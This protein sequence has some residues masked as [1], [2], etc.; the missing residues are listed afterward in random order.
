MWSRLLISLCVCRVHNRCSGQLKSGSLIEVPHC[1]ERRFFFLG[2][3]VLKPRLQVLLEGEVRSG[4]PGRVHIF[5][6]GSDETVWLTS[7]QLFQRIL[8]DS[9]DLKDIC[10]KTY[11]Y[12]MPIDGPLFSVDVVLESAVSLTLCSSPPKKQQTQ[13]KKK[14]PFGLVFQPRK[15][16]RTVKVS[17]ESGAQ[18]QRKMKQQEQKRAPKPLA[19]ELLLSDLGPGILG[20]RES[21]SEG[22]SSSGGAGSSNESTSEEDTEGEEMAAERERR[23]EEAATRTVLS[24]H[25]ELQAEK[26]VL[27]EKV[28]EKVAEASEASQPAQNVPRVREPTKCNS[29]IGIV[30]ISVQ[31]HGRLATCRHCQQKVAKQSGRIGYSFALQ[32]FHCYVHLGCFKSYLEKQAGDA[33]QAATFIH[34]WLESHREVREEIREELQ[35]LAGDLRPAVT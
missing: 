22:Q 21:E 19:Q 35:R 3:S 5:K 27:L 17:G 23:K 34:G 32:K 2:P 29:S 31:V 33:S 28:V 26:Q 14:L 13:K 30:D 15:R 20:F 4:D 24:S 9:G 7:H 11:D 1:T 12:N 18:R 25:A 10:L 16:R 6:K 8:E